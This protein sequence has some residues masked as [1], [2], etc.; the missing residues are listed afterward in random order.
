[1]NDRLTINTRKPKMRGGRRVNVYLDA[2]T[3]DSARK[4]GHGNLSDG[5]RRAVA[6]FFACLLR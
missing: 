6:R 3:L 1:M 2:A 4:I 5:L